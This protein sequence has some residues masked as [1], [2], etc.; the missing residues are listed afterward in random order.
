MVSRGQQPL[1]AIEASIPAALVCIVKPGIRESVLAEEH[2]RCRTVRVEPDIHL[3]VPWAAKRE[4]RSPPP[5]KGEALGSDNLAER[6]FDAVDQ[7]PLAQSDGDASS[8]ARLED[9]WLDPFRFFRR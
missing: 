1:H 7:P 4:V 2:A 9:Q 3:G 5:T 8:R 6:T